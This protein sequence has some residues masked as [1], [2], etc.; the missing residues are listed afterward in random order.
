MHVC[1]LLVFFRNKGTDGLC[2]LFSSQDLSLAT[3]DPP[4]WYTRAHFLPKSCFEEAMASLFSSITHTGQIFI[5]TRTMTPN[6]VCNI[7]CS[8]LVQKLQKGRI[9]FLIS[10]SSFSVLSKTLRLLHLLQLV[11]NNGTNIIPLWIEKKTQCQF[12]YWIW[13][14]VSKHT[15]A[16]RM[17]VPYQNMSYEISAQQNRKRKNFMCSSGESPKL[18]RQPSMSLARSASESSSNLSLSAPC[19]S[20]FVWI[21]I[22]YLL[23]RLEIAQDAHDGRAGVHINV[24]CRVKRYVSPTY[25]LKEYHQ[26]H[27]WSIPCVSLNVLLKVVTI[28]CMIAARLPGHR[29]KSLLSPVMGFLSMPEYLKKDSLNPMFFFVCSLATLE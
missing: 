4:S 22:E 17:F 25:V 14:P 13:C 23:P 21:N 28:I 29:T 12:M 9:I 6:I 27:G 1:L 11:W 10:G 16:N 24:I 15:K 20:C 18:Q 3:H 26:K 7:L 5:Q 8:L 19:F 2:P